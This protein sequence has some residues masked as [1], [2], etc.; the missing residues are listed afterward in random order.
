MDTDGALAIDIQLGLFPFF[1]FFSFLSR[2]S[3]AK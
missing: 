1:P 3:L 2:F